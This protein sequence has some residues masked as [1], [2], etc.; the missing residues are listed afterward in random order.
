[1]SYNRVTASP[2]R[3]PPGFETLLYLVS[4]IT[5]SVPFQY[6]TVDRI[7]NV[8]GFDSV[9]VCKILKHPNSAKNTVPPFQWYSTPL[10]NGLST[11]S[12]CASAWGRVLKLCLHRASCLYGCVWNSSFVGQLMLI[13]GKRQLYNTNIPRSWELFLGSWELFPGSWKL[14]SQASRYI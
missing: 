10:Q 1:M 8:S 11:C 4:F 13:F 7:S 9:W 14:V 6:Q 2:V 5:V 12:G 3:I